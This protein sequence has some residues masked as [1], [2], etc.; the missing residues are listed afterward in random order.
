MHQISNWPDNP[1]FFKDLVYSRMPD[2][3]GGYRFDGWISGRM[4]DLMAGYP[5]GYR[6]LQIAG[7]PANPL[8]I[9]GTG[10]VKITGN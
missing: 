6:I 9:T 1:A 7:Y 8:T 3:M 4:P 2:L 10:T 5:V